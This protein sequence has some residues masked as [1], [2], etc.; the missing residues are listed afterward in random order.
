[1][2]QER[3]SAKGA[4]PGEPSP[5]DKAR[6]AR[7]AKAV[8]KDETPEVR[9]ARLANARLAPTVRSIQRMANLARI[10]RSKEAGGG[11]AYTD[12]QARKIVATL[13]KAVAQVEAAFAGTKLTENVPTI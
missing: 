7:K 13:A 2:T 5:L 9:F 1:M 10:H 4:T 11:K 6:A 8:P 12:D 3:S